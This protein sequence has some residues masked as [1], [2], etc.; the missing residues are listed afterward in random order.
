VVCGAW[1]TAP[2]HISHGW[3]ELSLMYLGLTLQKQYC[4][5]AS[6]PTENL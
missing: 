2:T 3:I 6:Q 4:G 5:S 1:A